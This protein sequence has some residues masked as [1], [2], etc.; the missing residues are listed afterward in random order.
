MTKDELLYQALSSTTRLLRRAARWTGRRAARHW[1]PS[2][3]TRVRDLFPAMRTDA[4]PV[5]FTRSENR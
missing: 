3:P 4:R 2:E 1:R 5:V